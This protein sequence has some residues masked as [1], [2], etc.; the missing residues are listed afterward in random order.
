MAIA[1]VDMGT[2]IKNVLQVYREAGGEARACCFHNTTD[3]RE[4][5]ARLARAGGVCRPRDSARGVHVASLGLDLMLG[6]IALGA[7]RF[8]ILS[9][10]SE[11]PGYHSALERQMGLAQA[12]MSGLDLGEGRFQ[13][14]KAGNLAELEHAVWGAASP[15]TLT[16]ATFNLANEK[17]TTLDFTFD[18]FLRHA[19]VR[20]EQVALPSEA[21][22]GAVVVDPQKC[23]MC[24]ACVGA[25]PEGAYT[26]GPAG[27]IP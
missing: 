3:G 2:R 8:V 5:V 16:P 13:L 7:A 15:R 21:P 17:R 9:A 14:I 12:V 19:P 20:K 26:Q 11:P 1:R 4:L 22:Y 27:R 25:C 18:H 10:G 6:S 23:T 24:L